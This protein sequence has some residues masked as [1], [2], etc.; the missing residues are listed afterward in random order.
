M[1]QELSIL[2]F[3]AMESIAKLSRTVHVLSLD[4]HLVE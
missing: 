3:V 4:S 1:E 2:L